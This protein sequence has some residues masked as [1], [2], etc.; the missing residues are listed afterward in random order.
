MYIDKVNSILENLNEDYDKVK[1]EFDN[2]ILHDMNPKLVVILAQNNL[3]DYN[4]KEK[5]STQYLK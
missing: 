4:T 3:D 2:L 1:S 5:S